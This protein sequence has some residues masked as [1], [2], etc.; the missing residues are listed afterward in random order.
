MRKWFEIHGRFEAED[1]D[2]ALLWLAQHFA[3]VAHGFTESYDRQAAIEVSP[4]PEP[5]NKP[6]AEWPLAQGPNV[7]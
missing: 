4:L 6:G 3:N 1:I 7:P 5:F 2:E